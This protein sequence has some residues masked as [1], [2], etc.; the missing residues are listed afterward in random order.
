MFR[1]GDLFSEENCI[2]ECLFSALTRFSP[3]WS[4]QSTST[5]L[6][7]KLPDNH[8]DARDILSF[9]DRNINSIRPTRVDERCLVRRQA[10]K[11]IW[12]YACGAF[13]RDICSA[14]NYSG[15]KCAARENEMRKLMNGGYDKASSTPILPSKR[16][17]RYA[18]YFSRI[19]SYYTT[20]VHY[21]IERLPLLYSILFICIYQ[22]IYKKY[23]KYLKTIYIKI[24]I[25]IKIEKYKKYIK[26][27]KRSKEKHTLYSALIMYAIFIITLERITEC[28]VF[29]S[30]QYKLCFH[31]LNQSRINH[32]YWNY[33]CIMS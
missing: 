5:S 1:R 3:E 22:T 12:R 29:F 14:I 30:L 28:Y 2:R 8:L 27:I 25:K 24:Y 11:I 10:V 13:R 23:K 20:A 18:S 9:T 17:M 15:W 21:H 7:C 4:I 32:I 19:L 31:K 6:F 33:F 26:N 16:F